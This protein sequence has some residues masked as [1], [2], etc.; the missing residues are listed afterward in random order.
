MQSGT[1]ESEKRVAATPASIAM[2]QKE[3]YNVV[4]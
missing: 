2:L 3:G 1:R 4:S